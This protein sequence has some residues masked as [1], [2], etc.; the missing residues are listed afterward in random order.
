MEL[1][2]DFDPVKYYR[3]TGVFD[4]KAVQAQAEHFRP[5]WWK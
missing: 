3:L 2:P 5:E 4:E 1:Q